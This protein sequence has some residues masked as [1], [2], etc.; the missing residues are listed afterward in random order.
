MDDGNDAHY[1]ACVLTSDNALAT[2]L[3]WRISE[4][5]DGEK[6]NGILLNFNLVAANMVPVADPGGALILLDTEAELDRLVADHLVA[7]ALAAWVAVP[8]HLRIKPDEQRAACLEGL[9]VT[10]PVGGA[11]LPWS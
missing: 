4:I 6:S 5:L 9:A 7:P 1:I 2:A 8:V 11:V 10:L 3:V